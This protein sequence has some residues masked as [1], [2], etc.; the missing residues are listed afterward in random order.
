[1]QNITAA[2]PSS[3]ISF[4]LMGGL[5]ILGGIW[6]IVSPFVFGY[7]DL[8]VGKTGGQNATTMG[9][10]CGSIAILLAGFC[11]LTEK[12][13]T[14]QKSR[15]NAAI[16]LILLGVWLMAAPYLFNYADL[17]NPLYNLQITGAIF[18]IV[19]GYVFQAIYSQ[20]QERLNP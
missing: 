5:G 2:R 11:L 8:S 14:L 18:V 6:L 1:M 20:Y 16:G 13:P 17:R 3:M 19:A 10:I 12:M 7:N 9:I 4:T 15:F